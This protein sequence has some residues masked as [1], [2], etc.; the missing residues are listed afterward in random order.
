MICPIMTASRLA[1]GGMGLADGGTVECTDKCML[2]VEIEG[3]ASGERL[4][5]RCGLVNRDRVEI[6]SK[7]PFFEH[8]S[9]ATR[10]KGGR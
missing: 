3:E 4:G 7:E 1:G 9:A 5:W 10:K 2:A 8:V 6:A